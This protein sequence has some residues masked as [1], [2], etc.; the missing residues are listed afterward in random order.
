[1]T[2][3]ICHPEEEVYEVYDFV[4]FIGY[5]VKCR[6]PCLLWGSYT[7][8]CGGGD[9]REAEWSARLD[10]CPGAMVTGTN[11]YCINLIWIRVYWRL[12]RLLFC[13]SLFQTYTPTHTHTHGVSMIVI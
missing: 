8:P 3:L 4:L 6:E 9:W 10:Y 13:L 12:A 1:M 2:A 11:Q 5:G 7:Q